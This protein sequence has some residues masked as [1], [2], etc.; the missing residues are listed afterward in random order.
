MSGRSGERNYGTLLNFQLPFVVERGKEGVADKHDSS[1][2]DRN[3]Q[4]R[5][6]TDSSAPASSSFSSFSS[7]FGV[8]SYFRNGG[9]EGGKAVFLRARMGRTARTKGE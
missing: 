3:D 5:T 9:K 6:D 4:S 1:K 8:K 2:V 7:S